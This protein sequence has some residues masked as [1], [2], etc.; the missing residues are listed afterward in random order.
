MEF[1]RLTVKGQSFMMHHIRKMIGIT[2]A[3]VKG[4]CGED[5]IQK[6]WEPLKVDIPKAPGLGLL[7]FTTH[8]D[9]YNKRYGNDGLHEAIEWSDV[10][11]KIELFQNEVIFP[12]IIKSE[13]EEKSYPYMTFKLRNKTIAVV[14][15]TSTLTCHD[16][17]VREDG[18]NEI[19][20][21]YMTR[22]LKKMDKEA[23]ETSS[24]S[25]SPTHIQ[26]STEEA[27][28]KNNREIIDQNEPP[29]P[30][31]IQE[32]TEEAPSKN[33]EL[34]TISPGDTLISE[35]VV[36]VKQTSVLEPQL[37]IL[38]NKE[39]LDITNPQPQDKLQSIEKDI[40]ESKS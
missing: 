27:P 35:E 17:D 6:S 23:R 18:V 13:K 2:I 25:N 21:G 22:K 7:L 3:I 36:D 1:V 40:S 30:G 10:Q 34:P 9:G 31:Q 20:W 38:E 8:Y 11:D 5:V 28:S 4:L 19:R 24:G 16:F 15:Y 32:S 39:G 37:D 29:L 33:T 26:Q 14:S 12:H